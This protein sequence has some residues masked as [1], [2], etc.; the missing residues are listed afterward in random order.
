ML[1][2]R[3]LLPWYPYCSLRGGDILLFN[4]FSFRGLLVVVYQIIFIPT[5]QPNRTK[6]TKLET[7]VVIATIIAAFSC[8]CNVDFITGK[9]KEHACLEFLVSSIWNVVTVSVNPVNHCYRDS[10][11]SLLPTIPSGIRLYLTLDI[12]CHTYQNTSFLLQPLI[13]QQ[14]IY[15]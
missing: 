5:R 11:F 14:P 7:S 4:F 2:L 8:V 1:R 9:T 10:V 6:L 13:F 12:F 15:L 3:P